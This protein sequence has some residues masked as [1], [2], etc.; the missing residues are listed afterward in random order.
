M[1]SIGIAKYDIPDVIIKQP[2]LIKN[3]AAPVTMVMAADKGSLADDTTKVQYT[4]V[5]TAC[6]AD[7]A[8]A[9]ALSSAQKPMIKATWEGGRLNYAVTV[10]TSSIT[11]ANL[12]A[13]YRLCLYDAAS[14]TVFDL[15]WVFAFLSD[16]SPTGQGATGGQFVGVR[17]GV[18][19]A[20]GFVSANMA[21]FAG[22]QTIQLL[23]SKGQTCNEAN[24]VKAAMR[25]DAISPATS[26]TFDMTSIDNAN[27]KLRFKLCVLDSA[28]GAWAFPYGALGAE[29]LV[30]DLA[31]NYGAAENDALPAVPKGSST[32][33]Q[34][35]YRVAEGT[36]DTA[37]KL[38]FVETT[39]ACDYAAQGTGAKASDSHALIAGA[40]VVLAAAA[41]DLSSQTNV[42]VRHRLCYHDTASD[43]THPSNVR[44]S[45]G[46][47]E[48]RA[49]GSF[50]TRTTRRI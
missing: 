26:V 28:G 41:F 33:V 23:L 4:K 48:G 17:R 35:K 25:S 49:E 19:H 11:T 40:T 2:V 32:N 7:G 5:G 22:T 13:K 3:A 29:F 39:Q 34:F 42:N 18:T 8:G 31:L 46:L 20:V 6:P 37:D 38:Q 43:A 36:T 14:T 9:S 1:T 50:L 12:N 27:N 44:E 16:L 21:G 30:H 10:D 24:T 45:D 15:H 47:F